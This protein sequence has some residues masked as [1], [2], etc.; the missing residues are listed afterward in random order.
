MLRLLAFFVLA[1]PALAQGTGDVFADAASNA[2]TH[3][4]SGFV[5]PAKIG[6]FERDAVGARDPSAGWDFCSYSALDGVY[7]TITLAPLGEAYE[8]KTALALDFKEQEATGG[9]KIAE[10]PVKLGGASVYTRLYQTT[11]LADVHYRVLFAA[12]TAGPWA[13]QVTMEYASPRDDRIERE[14]LDAVYAQAF[15]TLAR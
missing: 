5:C 12:A 2:K 3:V 4:A 13:V 11:S 6:I 1:T 14:F 9:R 15:K 7:G 8:P 10:T